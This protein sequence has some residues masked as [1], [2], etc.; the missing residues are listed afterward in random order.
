MQIFYD[1]GEETMQIFIDGKEVLGIPEAAKRLK[2]S[3]KTIHL[4]LKDGELLALRHGPR[5][6][7]TIESIELLE[8]ERNK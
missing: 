7:V 8:K 3:I 4:W 6:Y 1:V 2:V 5:R